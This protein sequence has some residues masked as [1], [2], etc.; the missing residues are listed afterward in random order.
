MSVVAVYVY[1]SVVIKMV[2]DPNSFSLKWHNRF[3]DR[4]HIVASYSKDPVAGV[5][6][7]IVGSDKEIITDGFNGFPR[8]MM[9]PESIFEDREFVRRNI[10]H[11]EANALMNALRTGAR[12]SGGVLYTTR[13]P[14]PTCLGLIAQVDLS[15]VVVPTPPEAYWQESD[16]DGA[17][18]LNRFN[19]ANVSL[20][21]LDTDLHRVA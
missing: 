19:N 8:G 17:E 6:A 15:F 4:A 21:F 20:Y 3:M 9:E 1:T 10:V 13:I 12:V 7:V 2:I 16:H 11:A 14:C 5:G 18:I